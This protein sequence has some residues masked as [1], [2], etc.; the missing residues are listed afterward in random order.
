MT[1]AI[2]VSS[3]SDQL[4]MLTSLCL[5]IAMNKLASNEQV[6]RHQH[7]NPRILGEAKKYY[8]VQLDK[9][10]RNAQHADIS[11]SLEKP[12]TVFRI[13]IPKIWESVI[14]RKLYGFKKCWNNTLH[15]MA[16]ERRRLY[17]RA[18]TEG[19][20]EAQNRYRAMA[21]TIKKMVKRN[22]TCRHRRILRNLSNSEVQFGLRGIK[23]LMQELHTNTKVLKI[24]GPIRVYKIHRHTQ[25]P[26]MVTTNGGF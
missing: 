9:C 20:A 24:T 18:L 1:Y 8:Q 13:N 17:R 19:S 11:Y 3:G 2:K 26:G 7:N 5:E 23:K 14:R 6:P 25:K 4:P 22:K 16:K 21:R 15:R 12:Y 10:L